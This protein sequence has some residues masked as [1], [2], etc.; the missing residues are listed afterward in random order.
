[1]GAGQ[2]NTYSQKQNASKQ[3]VAFE[4]RGL[5]EGEH[6]IRITVSGEKPAA[7]QGAFVSIDAFNVLTADNEDG[8]T[9]D[10]PVFDRIPQKDGTFLTLHCRDALA[11]T[12]DYKAGEHDLY[13]TTSQIV[14]DHPSAKGQLLTLDGYPGDAGETVLHYS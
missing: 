10:A 12:A 14:G 5:T 4:K 8:P 9:G 3:F 13:Y 7:S 6:T 2:T 1:E 11:L